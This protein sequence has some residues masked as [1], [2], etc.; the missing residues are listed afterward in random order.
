MAPRYGN[1]A[2][3]GLRTTVAVLVGHMKGTTYLSGALEGGGRPSRWLLEEG[4][5]S[6]WELVLPL[7]A[8]CVISLKPARLNT[9]YLKKKMF[10]SSLCEFCI[11]FNDPSFCTFL[12]RSWWANSFKLH[13]FGQQWDARY[14]HKFLKFSTIH[15]CQK[16]INSVSSIYR[17]SGTF[18]F[19]IF[20]FPLKNVVRRSR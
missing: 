6:H 2:W 18:Y 15:F 3:T 11:H 5:V 16:S 12:P 9:F 17:L 4:L 1:Q 10:I 7:K 19:V 8:R 14:R 13:N 20:T